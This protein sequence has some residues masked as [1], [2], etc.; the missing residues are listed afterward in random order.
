M[1]LK[2][3]IELKSI[4]EQIINENKTQDQWSEIESS[5]MFQTKKYCGGFDALENEFCFSY[6]DYNKKEFWFQIS[7]QKIHSCL[8]NEIKS[9]KIRPANK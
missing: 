4:F 1:D 8:N 7:L 5:G 6:Y 3:D 9:I 2:I